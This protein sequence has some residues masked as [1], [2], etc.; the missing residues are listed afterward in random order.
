M[1]G[2]RAALRALKPV[3]L[4]IGEDETT[5]DLKEV[6]NWIEVYAELAEFCRRAMA[7]SGGSVAQPLEGW[8]SH[9]SQRLTHWRQRREELLK[10][11]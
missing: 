11:S 7:E 4:F 5:E 1:E 6:A 3:R 9:F 10:T 8:H 2:E